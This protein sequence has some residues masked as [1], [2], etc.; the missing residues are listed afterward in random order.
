MKSFLLVCD[1]G[2][3]RGGQGTEPV[4]SNVA[5]FSSRE[6][7]CI[8]TGIKANTGIR[9]RACKVPDTRPIIEFEKVVS[10]CPCVVSSIFFTHTPRAI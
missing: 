6:S 1:S 8:K 2:F 9:E 10:G 7:G 5:R 4:S 3:L